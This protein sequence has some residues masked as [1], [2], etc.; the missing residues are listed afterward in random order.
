MVFVGHYAH[1][2]GSRSM[3]LTIGPI[4]I[5]FN[6]VCVDDDRRELFNC[7]RIVNFL[8]G[9]TDAG[10]FSDFFFRAVRHTHNIAFG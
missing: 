7:H 9:D 10:V 5:I 3:K 8:N 4:W 2:N 1:N 6:F